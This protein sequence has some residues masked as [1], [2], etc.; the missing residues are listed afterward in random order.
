MHGRGDVIQVKVLG[1]IA[2]LDE[3]ETDWKL[4]AIDVTDPLADQLNGV[5]DVEKHYPGFIAKSVDWFRYYKVPD[6]KPKNNFAFDGEAKDR[7]YAMSVVEETHEQW[8][9]LECSKEGPDSPKRMN[10][11][12]GHKDQRISAADARQT[13]DAAPP[14]NSQGPPLAPEVDRWHY[15]DTAKC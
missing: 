5:A 13:V 15:V 9:D 7:D 8:K 6:G 12:Q 10:T 11:T 2:L 1:V 4:L 14:A 3:G